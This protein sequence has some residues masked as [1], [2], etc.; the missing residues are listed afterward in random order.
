[1][2]FSPDI[3]ICRWERDE[4]S[5]TCARAG[6]RVSVPPLQLE[7]RLAD[8]AAAAEFGYAALLSA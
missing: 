3:L 8:A 5:T 2:L 6:W 7:R 4:I 1:M